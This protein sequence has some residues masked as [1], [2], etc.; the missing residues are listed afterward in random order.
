MCPL[1]CPAQDYA[2]KIRERA[3]KDTTNNVAGWWH[4]NDVINDPV[5]GTY[6]R[7]DSALYAEA[8]RAYY[9]SNPKYYDYEEMRNRDRKDFV[10]AYIRKHYSN[11]AFDNYQK[12]I[13]GGLTKKYGAAIA[14]RLMAQEVW[15]GMTDKMMLDGLG[16]PSTIKR[17]VTAS[18]NTEDWYYLPDNPNCTGS[19]CPV[20]NYSIRV[21]NHKV[22]MLSEF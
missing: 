12:E 3:A 20:L 4:S 6:Q 18:G 9:N 2:K 5:I 13:K 19:G 15:I 7:K 11:I 1:L 21:K 22:V 10:E 16:R 17:T 8:N 14:K